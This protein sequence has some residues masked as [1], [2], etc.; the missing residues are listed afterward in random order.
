MFF[1]CFAD[2][3]KKDQSYVEIGEV[4]AV[5]SDNS[6]MFFFSKKIKKKIKPFGMAIPHYRLLM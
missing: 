5:N 3:Y 1:R 4:F 2:A 6:A